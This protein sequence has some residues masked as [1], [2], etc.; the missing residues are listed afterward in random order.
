MFVCIAAIMAGVSTA[1]V[2]SLVLVGRYGERRF[3]AVTVTVTALRLSLLKAVLPH[4]ILPALVAACIYSADMTFFGYA[5]QIYNERWGLDPVAAGRVSSAGLA[6][7]MVCSPLVGVVLMRFPY[8][9]YF[10][11]TGL[12]V[13]SGALA[14][15][16]A[17]LWNPYYSVP[18]LGL[19]M[20]L[21]SAAFWPCVDLSVAPE[22]IG[23][24][25]GLTLGT[26]AAIVMGVMNFLTFLHQ[27]YDNDY[28]PALWMLSGVAGFGVLLAVVWIV[29]DARGPK[30]INSHRRPIVLSETLDITYEE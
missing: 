12:A 19:G 2:I 11:A 28:V 17:T 24:A 13:M 23:T 22:H 14:V 8:R 29:Y 6:V 1:S 26:E 16:A 7:T 15:H 5:T 9:G 25:I 20:A 30:R 27:R 21:S 4:V 3:G 10:I 18:V